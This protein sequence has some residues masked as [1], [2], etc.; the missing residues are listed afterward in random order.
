MINKV[1]VPPEL[2]EPE[3]EPT[4]DEVAAEI[5]ECE[6]LL[7][8]ELAGASS[9]GAQDIRPPPHAGYSPAAAAPM[10]DEPIGQWSTTFAQTWA[11]VSEK[12]TPAA[13]PPG[14]PHAVLGY[15]TTGDGRLDAFD[16]NHDGVFDT[17][18]AA[19]RALTP[20]PQIPSTLALLDGSQPAFLASAAVRAEQLAALEQSTAAAL[21]SVAQGFSDKAMDDASREEAIQKIL[22]ECKVETYL[23]PAPRAD[24]RSSQGLAAADAVSEPA[25]QPAPAARRRG[26]ASSSSTQQSMRQPGGRHSA[27]RAAQRRPA[28]AQRARPSSAPRTRSAREQA[29]DQ[30]WQT[31]DSVTGVS[32]TSSHRYRQSREELEQQARERLERECTFKPKTSARD[33]HRQATNRRER[34]NNLAKNNPAVLVRRQEER[35]RAAREKMK[36]CTFKPNIE[37]GKLPKKKS[38]PKVGDDDVGDLAPSSVSDRLFHEADD[39]LA[40]RQRLRR[41]VEERQLRELRFKPQVNSP[42]PA[43]QHEA[44]QRPLHE[45]VAELQRAR[46][47]SLQRMRADREK[48][49]GGTFKPTI[50]QRSQQLASSRDAAEVP[51]PPHIALPALRLPACALRSRLGAG[52]EQAGSTLC[53][54]RCVGAFAGAR[55]PDSGSGDGRRGAVGADAPDVG[56][57]AGAELGDDFQAESQRPL[58]RDRQADPGPSTALSAPARAPTSHSSPCFTLLHPASPCFALLR[59]ASPCFTLHSLPGPLGRPLDCGLLGLICPPAGACICVLHLSGSCAL[60]ALLRCPKGLLERE[61]RLPAGE[62][63][64]LTAAIPI[65]NPHRSCEL[66]LTS[67]SGRSTLPGGPATCTSRRCTRSRRWRTAASHRRSAARARSWWRRGWPGRRRATWTESS[68]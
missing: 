43:Q 31:E 55:R 53:D 17:R 36:E 14:R 60:W 49:E 58:G 39:R 27:A 18:A 68:G 45:R 47:I 51:P 57:A 2:R 34:I 1:Y 61:L 8:M 20:P 64:R 66:T 24:S 10:S 40:S 54:C 13:V 16:T 9:S 48:A 50:G 52:W 23:A 67:C 62:L 7:T 3:R 35:E 21:A 46:H 5:A 26:S 37:H 44:H 63:S 22:A 65:E 41:E 12:A 19:P 30:A 38:D 11:D 42:S 29:M 59:P 4:L 15:D 25:P 32:E 6:D 28:S 33:R 56:R